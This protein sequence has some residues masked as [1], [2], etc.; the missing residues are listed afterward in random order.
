MKLADILALAKAGY[1]PGEI[2]EL[3]ALETPEP[4]SEPPKEDPEPE[5]PQPPEP[6]YKA[7][8]EDMQKKYEESQQKL[9]A[10]QKANIKQPVE[11]PED[12]SLEDLIR[13]IF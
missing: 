9:K 1:K 5:A 2:R 12:K 10:A 7:M 11:Q 6:D 13:D 8:Y 4:E 3:I